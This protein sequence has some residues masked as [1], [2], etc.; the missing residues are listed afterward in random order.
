MDSSLKATFLY[1]ALNDKKFYRQAIFSI[2]SCLYYIHKDNY[3]GVRIIVYTDNVKYFKDRIGFDIVEYV[4]FKENIQ[5]SWFQSA[6]INE[7][8]NPVNIISFIKP[9]CI[10][11]ELER[12]KE[13]VVFIDTDTFFIEH[14]IKLLQKINKNYSLMWRTE[15]I[16]SDESRKNWGFLRDTFK[17]HEFNISNTK[18]VL[19]SDLYMWNAGVIGISPENAYLLD[20]VID[21]SLQIYNLSKEKIVYQEQV[22]FSY[23]LNKHTKLL[24]AEDHVYHYCYGDIKDNF[25]IYLKKSFDKILRKNNIELI[26]EK[27]YQIITEKEFNKQYKSLSRDFIRFMFYSK[28]KIKLVFKR[29]IN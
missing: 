8:L 26:L 7:K 20:L 11:H 24:S 25:N 18:C 12:T 27:I 13:T 16:I 17:I 28:S 19:P 21:L 1:L 14:P 2:L 9:M 29:L 15:G 23:I 6:D 5:K 3:Q 22:M 4:E 10:K